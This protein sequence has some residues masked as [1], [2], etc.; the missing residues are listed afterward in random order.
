MN[1][2]LNRNDFIEIPKQCISVCEGDEHPLNGVDDQLTFEEYECS[3]NE[4]TQ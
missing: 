3:V 2:F 4:E 1:R